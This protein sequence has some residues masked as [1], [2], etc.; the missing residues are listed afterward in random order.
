MI[1]SDHLCKEICDA[2]GEALARFSEKNRI[3]DVEFGII[4]IHPVHGYLAFHVSITGDRNELHPEACTH[5]NI[6]GREEASWREEYDERGTLCIDGNTANPDEGDIGVEK[7][8]F[9]SIRDRLC[10]KLDASDF[11]VKVSN[12][13]LQV[14][15]S[16]IETWKAKHE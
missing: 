4:E 6:G 15:Y 12:W 16:A 13:M 9:K 8:L 5:P 7:L 1:K 11:S 2:L 14:G 3:S 10:D